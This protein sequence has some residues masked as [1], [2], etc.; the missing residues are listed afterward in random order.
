M[1]NKQKKAPRPHAIVGFPPTKTR[2]SFK[3]EC[4]VNKIV[5]TYAKTGMVNHVARVTP[6]YGDAPDIDFFS[7]ACIQAELR[8][9]EAQKALN[10]EEPTQDTPEPETAPETPPEAAEA[11]EPEATEGGVA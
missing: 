9:Q 3:D 1:T 6:E 2:N 7:A 8:S 4:D 10:P 11:T 5:A